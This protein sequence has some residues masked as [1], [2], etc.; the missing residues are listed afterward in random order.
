[1]TNKNTIL[2]YSRYNEKANEGMCKVISTLTPEEW[3][4]HF[5]GFFKSV[6]ELSAHIYTSDYS[7]LGRFN[8]LRQ[9]KS[10]QDPFL[11][12]KSFPPGTAYF[13]NMAEY[14]ADRPVLDKIIRN[15]AEEVTEE[16]LAGTLR[17]E[18]R[19]GTMER[20]FGG[21]LLQFFNHSAHHRG[22]NSVYL[23]LLGK[24]NDYNSF[25]QIL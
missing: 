9:F 19:G 18:T 20:N 17:F 22:M 2:L 25:S 4:K 3:T 14:L 5:D 23:E 15:F 16:D 8:N 12:A 24:E 11:T 21:W 6:R 7:Y 10:L 1:M 13:E